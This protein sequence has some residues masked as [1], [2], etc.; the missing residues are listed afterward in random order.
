MLSRPVTS[1]RLSR[2]GWVR[3]VTMRPLRF[4]LN[5]SLAVNFALAMPSRNQEKPRAVAGSVGLGRNE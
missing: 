5:A 3:T 4:P 2:I 1:P